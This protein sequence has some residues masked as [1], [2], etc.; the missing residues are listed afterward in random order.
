MNVFFFNFL[1]FFIHITPTESIKACRHI[2]CVIDL[3]TVYVRVVRCK[4][5]FRADENAISGTKTSRA[6]EPEN[7]RVRAPMCYFLHE[8]LRFETLFT[9][10]SA[11]YFNLLIIYL[12]RSTI[13]QNSLYTYTS[14]DR[15]MIWI[16]LVHFHNG[17]SS[18]S[19]S[20]C[21][22]CNSWFET[23]NFRFL[24]KRMWEDKKG[25]RVLVSVLLALLLYCRFL[26]F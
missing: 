25:I 10:F 3:I 11:T 17:F 1:F 20:H 14:G 15:Y 4:R 26:F 19:L 24:R 16:F 2:P 13:Q 8:S 22:K 5:E 12:V 6:R 9:L 7:Q 18:F 21:A 23:I